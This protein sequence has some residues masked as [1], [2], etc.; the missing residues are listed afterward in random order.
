MESKRQRWEVDAKMRQGPG[1][2]EST[3]E[4]TVCTIELPNETWVVAYHR[5]WLWTVQPNE[6]D[7]SVAVRYRIER[8]PG[9]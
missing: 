4:A 1:Q 9:G 7:E 3:S 5:D 2:V 6:D 8:R